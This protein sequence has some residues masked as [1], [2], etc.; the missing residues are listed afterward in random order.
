MPGPVDA[1]ALVEVMRWHILRADGQRSG[2]WTRAAAIL[3]ANALVVAGTAVMTSAGSNAAW[4]SLITAILPLVASLLSIYEAS[5][6]LGGMQDWSHTFVK[7]DSPKPILYSLPETV[8]A[9]DTYDNFRSVVMSRS[10]DEEMGDAMSELWRISVLHRLRIHQLRRSL[11]WFEISVP[12]L[13]ISAIVIVA[14]LAI[15]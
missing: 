3:S 1:K 7:Q 14:S 8:N 4:W 9:L 11:R 6:V 15:S 13:V 12:L 5:N 2:L 10:I